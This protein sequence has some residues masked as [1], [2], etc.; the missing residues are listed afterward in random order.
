MVILIL[1]Q[2]FW[3]VLRWHAL[4]RLLAR[5]FAG[6]DKRLVGTTEMFEGFLL[7][8]TPVLAERAN[9]FGELA[10]DTIHGIR[11]HSQP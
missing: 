5:C 9:S 3:F 1:E 7:V 10:A 6:V 8:D 2:A 11:R 4:T